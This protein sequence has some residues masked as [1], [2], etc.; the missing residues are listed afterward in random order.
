MADVFGPETIWMIVGAIITLMI[1]SYLL[2]DNK[3]YRWAL[4]L[5]VGSGF[6]YA[7]GVAARFVLFDWLIL[8]RDAE[9]ME[10]RI[11]YLVPI[12]LG[13]LLF[14]KFF[15]SSRLLGPLSVLG[16]ISMGYLLGVGAAVSIA[17]ALLGTLFPQIEAAGKA[18]TL[19]G[20]PFVLVQGIV[21]LIGTIAALLVFSPRPRTQDG[22]VKP[23]LKWLQRVGNFFISVALAAAF[24][25]AVTTG[26]TLWVE[27]WSQIV[28]FIIWAL[29]LVGAS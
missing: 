15:A 2:G 22:E 14:L 6:G 8:A 7:M 27:R 21:M 26:L 9:S 5:L 25:G 28:G 10:L 1:F 3:L 11:F 16:N 12:V 18:L 19:T 17:G 13:G 29:S 4:A 24:A 20:S 23:A